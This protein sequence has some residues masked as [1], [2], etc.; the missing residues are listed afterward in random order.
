MADFLLRFDRVTKSFLRK[1]V[2]ALDA[3]RV[4]GIKF[5]HARHAKEDTES[6]WSNVRTFSIKIS[7]ENFDD[8]ISFQISLF[9]SC[10]KPEGRIFLAAKIHYFGVGG[11]IR[12]FEDALN[13][14]KKWKFSTVRTY[15]VGVAREI[16]QISRIWIFLAVLC[17]IFHLK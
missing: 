9:D 7:I 5:W 6:C 4:W 11:G 12:L 8:L 1:Y 2:Y 16:I 10:L 15:E 13:K 3:N 17:S 14:T